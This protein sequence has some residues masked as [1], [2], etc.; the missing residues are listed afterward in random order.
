MR[1]KNL[2]RMMCRF[3]IA[4]YLMANAYGRWDGA[5][6]AQRHESLSKI[7]VAWWFSL[8]GPDEAGSL[9]TGGGD[10]P[11]QLVYRVVHDAT[12]DLTDNMDEK[13]GFPLESRPNYGELEPKFFEAF[14]T[15]AVDALRKLPP[16]EQDRR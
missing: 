1:E 2:L 15:L 16:I 11:T 9:M 10:R 12:Q 4:R 3:E 5:E 8:E 7:F 13:I 14:Y 6:K